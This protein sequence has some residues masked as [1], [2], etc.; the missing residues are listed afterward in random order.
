MLSA[1]DNELVTRVGPGT[2][3]GALFREY[4][5][6]ILLSSELPERDGMPCRV[7]IL[8]EDLVAFRTTSGQVG[9]LGD[10]CP[11]RGAPRGAAVRLSRLEVRCGRPLRGHAERAAGE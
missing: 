5:L 1:A 11:H 9:L 8:G 4:W 2:P 6:P 3:M 10:K 7:R